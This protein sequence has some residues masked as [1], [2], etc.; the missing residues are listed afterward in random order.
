[1]RDCEHVSTAATIPISACRAELAVYGHR[2]ACA[3]DYQQAVCFASTPIIESS[4]GKVSTWDRQ[5]GLKSYPEGAILF[6]VERFRALSDPVLTSARSYCPASIIRGNSALSVARVC[7]VRS[8][9]VLLIC[10][11]RATSRSAAGRIEIMH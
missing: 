1:M 2:V 5:A 7:A 3:R 8:D 11:L 6:N 10:C 4:I 9:V